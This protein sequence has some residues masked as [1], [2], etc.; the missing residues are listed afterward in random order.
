MRLKRAAYQLIANKKDNIINVA[1]DTGFESHEAFSRAFKKICGQSPSV[2]RNKANW[3][4]WENPPYSLH[5]KGK[6][7][8]NITIKEIPTIRTAVMEHY[9][10]PLKL[11]YTMDKLISWAKVQPIDLKPKSGMA[12]G[13]G[14]HDPREVEAEE[15]RFDLA[16]KVPQDFKLSNEVTERFIPAGRYAIAIHK[17]SRDNIGDTVYGLYRDWLPTS[18]E[19]LGDFPC[20]FCYHN[21]D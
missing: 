15:F 5:M 14:Y 16:L 12:F 11:S 8:M 9:G 3:H 13:F 18:G 6:K 20:I 21:F 19:E 7:I 4:A 17:G 2:F 1:L 10:D